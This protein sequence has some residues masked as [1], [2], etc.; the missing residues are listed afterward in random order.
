MLRGYPKGGPPPEKQVN[1]AYIQAPKIGKRI[2]NAEGQFTTTSDEP[3]A[4]QAR[5]FLRKKLVGK[6]V[7]FKKEYTVPFAG[8]QRECGYLFIEQENVVESLVSAGLADVIKRKQ[9]AENPVVLRLLELENAAIAAGLGKHSGAPGVKRSVS[10]IVTEPEKLVNKTFDGIVEHVMSGSTMRIAVEVDKLSYRVLTVMLSGIKGPSQGEPFFG[11]AKFF[12]ESRL[13]QRDV[14]VRIE[15]VNPPSKNATANANQGPSFNGSVVC[16]NN[17]IAE[18]L[19]KE[20]FAKCMDWSLAQALDSSKLRAAEKEAKQKQLRLWRDYTIQTKPSHGSFFGKVVEVVNADALM[21]E[22]SETKEIKKI[23][24]ASI[25]PPPRKEGVQVTRA[26]YDV[27]FMFEAREFLRTKTFGKKVKVQVDYIQPKVDNT[28]PEKVCASV[29]LVENNINIAEALLL[30]G[31]A[32]TVRYKPDDEARSSCYDALRDAEAKATA[33]KWGIHGNPEKG[34]VRIVDLSSDVTKAKS[35]LPSL[36]RGNTKKDSIVE[37]VYS[38][39]RIKV[40]IPKENCCL[41][42]ILAGIS[43]PKANDPYGPESTAFA[44][45]LILQRSVQITVESMDK[46]GNFIGQVF[47]HNKNLAFDL[48]K[49]GYA[50]IRDERGAD[51]KAA[52]DEA[53]KKR[54]NIWKDFKE[55]EKR[56]EADEDNNNE[57]EETATNGQV[58][59][60]EKLESRTEVVVTQVAEDLSHLFVQ[61]M[62]NGP[63][64]AKLMD[65]LREDFQTNPPLPGAYTPK[66][67]DVVA[68]K[69]S[70]DGQWYRAR[71]EKIIDKNRIEVTYVDYG[72]KELVKSLDLAALPE[73]KYLLNSFPEGTKKVALAF[74]SLP[75]DKDVID[76]TRQ[77]L[78]N[79]VFSAESLLMREEYRDGIEYVTL[80][81]P[82]TKKDIILKLVEDG[83]FIVKKERRRERKIQKLLGDY[84]TAQESAKKNRVSLMFHHLVFSSNVLFFS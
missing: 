73:T 48:L 59:G 58:N 63:A 67:G 74:V 35:F 19:L 15:A 72:N 79:I 12:T 42:V 68:A 37:H 4:W 8:N 45:S 61:V 52:E 81:D 76:D 21:I 69:F 50:S 64:L 44:K 22:H 56:P 80:V 51:L 54:L 38:A 2:T 7:Q 6:E 30:K 16:N 18:H 62:S 40:F 36:T 9:N 26:L 66:K 82:T 34:I 47:H 77:I 84:R 46:V 43:T 28:Y 78:E 25:R 29:F 14:K 11:E 32:T 60:T 39:S 33:K 17:N 41:N 10:D 20:G 27:P 31:L 57:N 75:D 3:Y 55:D 53:K 5:E 24:L 70:A 83:L 65:E 23:F 71:I 1:L 13:L 49:A